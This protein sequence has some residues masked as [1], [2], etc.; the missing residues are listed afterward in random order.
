MN[1][2]VDGGQRDAVFGRERG[3]GHRSGVECGGDLQGSSARE[4]AVAV[5][6]AAR[7]RLVAHH[8]L[9]VLDL[10]AALQ[11][12]NAVLE[13]A[14]V[15]RV[16][17]RLQITMDVDEGDAVGEDPP[18]AALRPKANDAV[19]AAVR[20]TAPEPVTVDYLDAR[21]EALPPAVEPVLRASGQGIEFTSG[22]PPGI[23]RRRV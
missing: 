12:A 13:A 23:S 6:L 8:V 20:S 9:D 3:A 10:V 1:G 22:E 15:E 11:A 14:V 4:G 7:H 21:P 17:A 16:L 5:R 19:A 2:A 18:Q